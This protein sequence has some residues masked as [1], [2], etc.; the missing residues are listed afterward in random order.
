MKVRP[1]YFVTKDN[2][3]DDVAA[4][5]RLRVPASYAV[6]SWPS[7]RSFGLRLLDDPKY[8]KECI[9]QCR[10]GR[11]N[12]TSSSMLAGVNGNVAKTGCSALSTSCQRYSGMGKA[13]DANIASAAAAS[14]FRSTPLKHTVT[15]STVLLPYDSSR[16]VAILHS[17]TGKYAI[18]PN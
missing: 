11:G 1:L 4:V 6:T 5:L 10:C 18:F 14:S 16:I 13:C 2:R 17:A 8:D 7:R 9:G 15:A 12:A 3:L